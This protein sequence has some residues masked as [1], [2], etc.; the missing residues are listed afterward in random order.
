M[1]IVFYAN[2]LPWKYLSEDRFHLS[3]CRL[4]AIKNVPIPSLFKNLTPDCRPISVKSKR[5]SIP[6]TKFIQSEI[7]RIRKEG[8][9]ER[10]QSPWR[11]QTLIVSPENHKK[12]LVVDYS[13]TI[14]LFTL[15]DAYPLSQIADMVNEIA[16]YQVF[17]TLDLT[18][19]Y[20]QVAL[21]Q[22]SENILHLKLLDLYTNFAESHS[23]WST[24]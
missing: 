21:S 1:D 8:I 16:S 15:L 23:E 4:T 19:V 2:I 13:Q 11:A 7:S 22:K 17:S 6:D 24:E 18:S 3:V 10:S 20:H 9:I 5:H 14:N 12:R